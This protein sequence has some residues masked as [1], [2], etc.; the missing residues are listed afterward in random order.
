M[1]HLSP[2]SRRVFQKPSSLKSSDFIDDASDLAGEY[3][4][5]STKWMKKN[6]GKALGGAALVACV[7]VLGY[8]IGRGFDFN[9]GEKSDHE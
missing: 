6:Y 8:L 5:Q 1:A 2:L 3:L 9:W 4:D 7:G